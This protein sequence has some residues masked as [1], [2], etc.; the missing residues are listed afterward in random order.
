VK[1]NK[2]IL[3][4]AGGT[5]GHIY[6]GIAIADYLKAK[7]LSITW[8]GTKQGM[9]N[10]LIENKPYK[11]A[12]IDIA[13]V[14]GKNILSWLK[15]PFTL[16]IACS[17]C[18]KVIYQEKPD[19]VIAMGGYVSFP[20]GVMARLMRRPLIVHEQNSIPGLTNK[21]LALIATRIY[22]AFP[23]RLMRASQK[24]G[25]PVRDSIRKIEKP[26]Q[27]FKNRKGP[28]RLL[29]VGG[30]LGAKFFNET[31]PL[32]IQQINPKKRPLIIHQSGER[33]C[34]ELKETY[35]KCRVKSDCRAYLNDIDKVYAWADIVIA[36]AGALT[37]SE[38]SAAGIASLLVPFPFA[39]DNHQFY[40][41][42]YLSDKKAARLIIQEELTVKD[43]SS[44]I[45]SLTRDKCLKMSK[46]A[47]ENIVTKP[48]EVIYRECERLIKK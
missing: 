10:K 43:L 31:I 9:E 18:A 44:F 48:E 24:I 39:V 5:G 15:L 17:Q 35:K 45:Q 37:V 41:A 23:M 21:F 29:V 47:L 16:L 22:S 32:S 19:I 14:R 2:K 46:L 34:K 4:I 7:D 13:G 27:R 42:K 6:P 20:G 28:L 36:R 33:N 25:N 40:N 38:F 3:I 8:L 26:D 12:M 30:S 11:K 1:S